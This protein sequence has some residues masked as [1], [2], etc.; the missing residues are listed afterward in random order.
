MSNATNAAV[1]HDVVQ[2]HIEHSAV[3]VENLRFQATAELGAERLR[4]V[5]QAL[6]ATPVSGTRSR[7]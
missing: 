7:L 4:R 6:G 3:A 1:E 2:R 5:A